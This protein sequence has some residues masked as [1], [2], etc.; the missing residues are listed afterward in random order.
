[1]RRGEKS[2][3]STKPDRYYLAYGSNL[4][5][6]Q[7]TK[8]CPYCQIA[9]KTFIPGCRLVFK[10][11]GTGYYATLEEDREGFV[12]AMV[13]RISEYDESRLDTYEGC[14]E[15]YQKVW[16]QLPYVRWTQKPNARLTKKTVRCMAY[17]LPEDRSYGAPTLRYYDTLCLGYQQWR[18][19][20]R[21][22]EQA[23]KDTLGV[24]EADR[25]LTEYED[26]YQR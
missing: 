10:K 19:H 20:V 14:P 16:F 2:E 6:E 18:M 11:S 9:G 21:D 23:L 26:T 7:M 8:R 15:Q 12:Q 4:S 24:E 5:Y 13:F 17:V 1:M 22:L 3:L 25:F